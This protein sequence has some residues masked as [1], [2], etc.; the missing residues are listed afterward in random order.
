MDGAGYA[1]GALARYLTLPTTR[2]H[3]LLGPWDHGARINVSPWRAGVEP[4]F[5]LLG[6][7]LRFFDHYLMGRDTGL[8]ARRRSTTSP[9]TRRPGTPPR[10][11]RR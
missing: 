10:T 9:C 8:N 1:N 4:D 3:L 7:V 5:P 11:G 2:A 6:E